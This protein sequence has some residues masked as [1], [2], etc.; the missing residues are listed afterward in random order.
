MISALLV[1]SAVT[2]AQE[3]KRLTSAEIEAL[4]ATEAGTGTSGVSGIKTR[5]LKGDPTKSGLYTIR[6]RVPAN[7]T[8]QAHVHPDDRSS[9][10][11]A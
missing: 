8:I 5:V 2:K 9:R 4:P 11:P 7:T 3:E 6:L 1:M 10:G